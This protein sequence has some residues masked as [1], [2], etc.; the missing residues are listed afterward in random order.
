VLCPRRPMLILVLGGV[1]DD[2]LRAEDEQRGQRCRSG[3]PL[4]TG[5]TSNL[6]RVLP[7]TAR[8]SARTS[9]GGGT[10][11]VRVR[12][13]LSVVHSS[14]RTL[15]VRAF[16][17][18]L[19]STQDR[20]QNTCHPPV[21]FLSSA[22]HMSPPLPHPRGSAPRFSTSS[23]VQPRQATCGH[24]V[25]FFSI[26]LPVAHLPRRHSIPPGP[27]LLAPPRMTRSP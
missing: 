17:G 2:L 5:H 3:Q 8:R 13:G 12:V 16:L 6:R 10:P 26:C 1:G 20:P 22:F 15:C 21:T 7:R 4:R 23:A 19:S 18:Q 25:P 11:G 27:L 24:V 9:T 14:L